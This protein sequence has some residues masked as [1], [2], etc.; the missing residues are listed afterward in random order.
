MTLSFPDRRTAAS[1]EGWRAIVSVKK[2]EEILERCEHLERLK[3]SLILWCSHEGLLFG[4]KQSSAVEDIGANVQTLHQR[5]TPLRSDIAS[6]GGQVQAMTGLLQDTGRRVE[7]DIQCV[8]NQLTPIGSDLLS[9]GDGI[10]TANTITRH[11]FH[12]TRTI[13]GVV[14]NDISMMRQEM[15]ASRQSPVNLRQEDCDPMVR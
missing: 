15:T 1:K 5:V 12:A 4:K 11:E 2:E 9:V 6:V 14:G 10:N 3:G 8:S 7:H 13:L